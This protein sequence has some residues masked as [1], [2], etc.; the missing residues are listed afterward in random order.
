MRCDRRKSSQTIVGENL[1]MKKSGFNGRNSHVHRNQTFYLSTTA[2]IL[3]VMAVSI[4]ERDHTSSRRAVFFRH[5]I[6]T[7][8][9]AQPE[10]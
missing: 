7:Q 3:M 10:S 1:K 9:V 5:H 8:Q 2:D 6:V 4:R